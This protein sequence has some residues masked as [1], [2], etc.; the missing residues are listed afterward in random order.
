MKRLVL[1]VALAALAGCT[2][3]LKLADGLLAFRVTLVAG[4]PTG[5]EAQPLPFI[6]GATCTKD[7]DCENGETCQDSRCSRC[8]T[9]DVVARGNDGEDYPHTGKL[10]LDVTPGFVTSSTRYFD[11]KD[12]HAQGI[13][14]CFNRTSGPTNLWV[15]DDGMVLGQAE[16]KYG[17][18]NDGYDN[19]GNGWVDLFDAGCASAGDD[20][21]APV[22]G[23]TGL[24][25]TL[26]FDTP[27]IRQ[28]QR[29]D[30]VSTSPMTGQQVL[31]DRGPLL[32]TNVVT[33]GFY[34]TDVLDQD[35]HEPA[36]P[37]P[38]LPRPFNSI[39]VFTF[40]AP[41]GVEVGNIACTFA[42][43]IQEHVG[44]TQV[45]FPS[46]ETLGRFSE[47]RP[48]TVDEDCREDETCSTAVRPDGGCIKRVCEH[49]L[50]FLD[51]PV[52]PPAGGT[53]VTDALVAESAKAE[54]GENSKLLEA[55][56]S[57]LVRVSNM[58]VSTR[59]IA[60]DRD[61]N[62]SIEDGDEDDCRNACQI[63]PLCTDL[64][65]FFE[66]RQ[67]SGTV[68]GKKKMGASIARASSF[69]PLAIDF[70]GD[71]DHN[72]RCEKKK[73]DLGF[74]EYTCPARVLKSI[75]GS[76]HHIYLCGAPKPGK[77]ADEPAC[78]LQFWIL[79]PR[80][81]QDV[82]MPEDMDQDGDGFKPDPKC[83]Q[84]AQP[85][86]AYCSDKDCNDNDPKAFPGST[87]VPGNGRDDDCD[88]VSP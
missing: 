64:E 47:L 28:L 38:E 14:V 5:T 67:W 59:L 63:D 68:S 40:S 35:A 21:E 69:T 37:A 70:L 7:S 71:D 32:V 30:L 13:K 86:Q 39:F 76:L 16:T 83:I 48:C 66:Y 58:Q 41:E 36:H 85:D 82:L 74:L 88:G 54:I 46:F 51:T 17:E 24:S 79:D 60:C 33:N 61:V 6:S 31:V 49:I 18:C 8:Y 56:E 23:A 55:Y 81:D 78:G 3:R 19:D 1:I 29:G 73:T 45:V 43:G 57:G 52:A 34:V 87:E 75:S 77:E 15:E 20:L 62:G 53:D 65:G 4:Q 27:S 11:M 22:T 10:H 80:F 50:P 25:E 72:H 44:Q 12:G 42:G 84:V 26:W 9:L 2:E